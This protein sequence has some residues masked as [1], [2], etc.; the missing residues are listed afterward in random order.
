M[1]DYALRQ[2]RRVAAP[3]PLRL[4]GLAMLLAAVAWAIIQGAHSHE[5]LAPVEADLSSAEVSRVINVDASTGQ[6]DLEGLAVEP[7]EVVEF[8]LDGS[9]GSEHTFLLSGLTGAEIDQ[10]LAPNGDTIIRVRAPQHGDLSFFC[11][12]PG[13][14]GLHGTLVVD[15]GE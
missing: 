5:G 1:T 6:L 12:I 10:R 15:V 4:A 13:H 11:A 3:S 14:E 8:V 7:G 2:P 9:A